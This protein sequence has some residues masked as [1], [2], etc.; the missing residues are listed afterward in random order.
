MS[1]Y[2]KKKKVELPKIFEAEE[3]AKNYVKQHDNAFYCKLNDKIKTS[4]P[5]VFNEVKGW[6]AWQSKEVAR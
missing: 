6:Y 4:N 5:E 2:Q 3:E 1:K